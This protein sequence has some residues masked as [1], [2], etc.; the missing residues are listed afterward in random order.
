[1]H[2]FD[3]YTVDGSETNTH[4]SLYIHLLKDIWKNLQKNATSKLHFSKQFHRWFDGLKTI[5]LLKYFS[6]AK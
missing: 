5:R 1:M 6:E 2:S 4:S 3:F